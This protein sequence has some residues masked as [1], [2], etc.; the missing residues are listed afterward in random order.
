MVTVASQEKLAYIGFQVSISSLEN[1]APTKTRGRTSTRL[2]DDL[3][4]F[5][6]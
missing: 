6:L 5:G 2:S 3:Q 1:D 4:T